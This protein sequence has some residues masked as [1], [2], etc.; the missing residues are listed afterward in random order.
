[1]LKF[2]I[3]ASG[4]K[5][6]AATGILCVALLFSMSHAAAAACDSSTITDDNLAASI[7]NYGEKCKVD[8]D[9]LEG[10]F[11]AY[12]EK[13]KATLSEN[14]QENGY[15]VYGETVKAV[16]GKIGDLRSSYD[17]YPHLVDSLV[18][19][20]ERIQLALKELGE[21]TLDN[22]RAF[23][24]G[25]WAGFSQF[26]LDECQTEAA[27]IP[28]GSPDYIAPF[29]ALNLREELSSACTEEREA[30]QG[31]CPQT[32]SLT[33]EL[34]PEILVMQ[35]ASM[36]YGDAFF[37]E[38][39]MES[40]RYEREWNRFLYESKT[41]LPFDI[42]LQ[43]TIGMNGEYYGKGFAGP[44]DRQYF[45]LHPTAAFENVSDAQDGD[46]TKATFL[47]EVLGVNFW[48]EEDQIDLGFTRL[49]GAG[50]IAT[51][52]DRPGT[53]EWGYGAQLTFSSAY[54]IGVTDRDGDIGISLSINIADL[55]KDRVEP[56]WDGYKEGWKP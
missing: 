16:A 55:W 54:S 41:Q 12:Q 10:I 42:W 34:L 50:I 49:S 9:I 35:H 29:P 1:M 32:L 14:E 6:V 24:A 23:K 25:C 26:F 17:D 27:E 8:Q 20:D 38:L 18:S 31:G 5:S 21:R 7:T 3:S 46:R 13:V 52:S 40:A 4:I 33:R 48:R 2:S 37:N 15:I 51:Y 30:G 11:A 44:P 19:L 47:V 39:A 53:K 43:D 45:L 28:P 36:L 22:N 56:K